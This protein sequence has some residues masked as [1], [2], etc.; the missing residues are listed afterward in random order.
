MKKLIIIDGYSLLFRAYYATAYGGV[1]TIMRTKTGIP[2]NAIFAFANMIN[3]II[4]NFKGDE[5]LFVGFD[6]GGPC[7]RREQYADYKAN[8]APCPEELK[9]Q[10]PIVR[11]LLDALSI[12]RFEQK[13]FEGDDICGSMAKKASAANYDVAIY[14]SDRDFLQL[15]DQNIHIEILKKGMSDIVSVNQN[16]IVSLFGFTANQ[17]IDFKGLRGDTSDNLPGIPGVGEKTATKLLGQYQSFENIIANADKIG[18][19]LGENLKTYQAQGAKSKFLATIKTDVDVPLSLDEL[20]YHGYSF[21]LINEFCQKYELKSILNRLP[22]KLKQ[23][24]AVKVDFVVVDD[25]PVIIDKDIGIYLNLDGDNY[26]Q[27]TIKSLGIATKEKTYIIYANKLAGAKNLTTLLESSDIKKYVYD[28]KAIKVALNKIN[29]KINGLVFDLLLAAYLL[30]SSLKNDVVSV[31]NYF[32]VDV[33]QKAEPNLL[34]ENND[35]DFVAKCAYQVLA[36]NHR[37]L[38]E[39][40]KVSALKLFNELE[41]PLADVLAEM[42]IEGFPLDVHELDQIG[43]TFKEKLAKITQE[44]YASVGFEFNIASPKQ[45]ADV[46]FNRLAL[47]APH[48]NSTSVEVLESLKNEH[49]VVAKILEHRKYAKLISTYVDALKTHLH[50]DGKIHAMFNQALTTTGRLSS[51]EPNLQNISVRDEEGRLIRKAFHYPNHEF[52]I[53]SFDYSQIELRIL[54]ALAS[55]SG[56][57]DIFEH[58]RDIHT[59]TAKKVFHL[60]REPN[61]VERRKA[62]AVNFGIV[63]GISEFGLA[64]D[65]GINRLEAREI[66]NNFYSAYPEVR[67]FLENVVLN[68]VKNN[69]VETYFKRRRYLREIHDQNYQVREFAKRAAMNA[70]I[71][72][73]AADI[74]KLAMIK[75][76]AMLKEKH[77][78]SR[79]VLQIHDELI[80]KVVKSEQDALIHDVQTIMENLDFPIKLKVAM[81][82]GDTWY[83]A[84]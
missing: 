60:D 48:N 70:P 24:N 71:Q 73:T 12:K 8:R 81:G 63:Y 45:V 79:L 27:A 65:L 82:V 34:G 20:V 29:L 40:N 31:M 64:E 67:T 53:L 25:L 38:D 61:G 66:I 10:M 49:P 56:L 59:E 58:D 69:Y 28:Y 43:N 13:G 68:A 18:G 15:V 2:T 80:F 33:G 22:N 6:A 3:K 50:E 77:Y 57:K 47:P 37:V 16:N 7:F 14:T 4:A 83:E 44:I 46:L 41:L 21:N 75:V 35:D 32:N 39:L 78:Q 11:E 26:H 42:E 52:A 1:D 55:S 5:S 19:K 74:I 62:K 76:A 9:Q 36:L 72:G 30:D 51:S 84:K 17:L 54:A 23:S